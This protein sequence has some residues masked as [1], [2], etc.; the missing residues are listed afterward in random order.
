[1][2]V[3]GCRMKYKKLFL[4]SLFLFLPVSYAF[5]KWDKPQLRWQQAYRTHFGRQVNQRLYTNRVSLAFDYL[6]E[7]KESL[8]KV[9]PFFEIRH[10]LAKSFSERKEF[11]IEIGKDIFPW[12]YFGEG[13]QG[14]WR[15]EDERYYSIY[16]K[17]Y[18]AQAESRI[19]LSHNLLPENFIPL[20]GFI[21]SEY[22]YDF[23]RRKGARNEI[24]LGVILPLGK[25]VETQLNWRHIDRIR[26]YDSD[27][28]EGSLTL[29]F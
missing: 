19:I 24:G 23:R 8:L 16:E 9:M 29:I 25:H 11:G 5:A 1:M 20:K 18:S 28:V 7:E 2:K 14:A 22:T 15:N 26:Y 3:S 21:F 12:F 13:I 6:N 10:N 4:V 17:R 27:N